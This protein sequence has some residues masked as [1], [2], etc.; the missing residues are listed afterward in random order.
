MKIC[1]PKRKAFS[2]SSPDSEESL[3]VLQKFPTKS[4]ELIYLILIVKMLFLDT[5]KHHNHQ[6]SMEKRLINSEFF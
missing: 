2:E 1:I 6:L 3:K 5:L 4:K